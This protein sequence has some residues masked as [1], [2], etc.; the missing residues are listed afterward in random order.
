MY[1]VTPFIKVEPNKT[2]TVPYYTTT[3]IADENKLRCYN[4]EKEPCSTV[5]ITY[6]SSLKRYTFTTPSNAEYIM[7]TCIKAYYGGNDLAISSYE[8]SR[9]ADAE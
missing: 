7:F 3:E 1:F 6:H 8:N 4:P 2:Y 5:I 9:S